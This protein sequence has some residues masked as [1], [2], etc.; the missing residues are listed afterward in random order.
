ME[1]KVLDCS[2]V[3][4]IDFL[5]KHHEYAQRVYFNTESCTLQHSPRIYKLFYT[6]GSTHSVGSWSSFVAHVVEAATSNKQLNIEKCKQN[7]LTTYPEIKDINVRVRYA[8]IVVIEKTQ[9][10]KKKEEVREFLPLDINIVK[11]KAKEL[12]AKKFK[13]WLKEYLTEHEVEFSY[14]PP[15]GV[16]KIIEQLEAKLNE[17]EDNE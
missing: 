3:D 5:N 15:T 4:Y 12:S 14:A 17:E 1:E 16:A 10:G 13:R 7:L 6:D 8:P 2:V 11:E 9:A